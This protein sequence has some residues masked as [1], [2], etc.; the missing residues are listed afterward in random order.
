MDHVIEFIERGFTIVRGLFSDDELRAMSSALDNVIDQVRS[1]PLEYSVR[2]TAKDPQNQ[3]TWGVNY[4]FSRELYKPAFAIPFES[5]ALMTTLKEILGER[6]RFGNAHALWSPERVD[7]EL[8]WHRDSS[9]YRPEHT[10]GPRAHVQFNVCLEDDSSFRAVPGSHHRP[11][12]DDELNLVE[13]RQI[14]PLPGEEV[15][16]CRRGDVLLMNAN[17]VHRGSCAAGTLRRTLH[18]SVQPYGEASGGH[19]S[20]RFMRAEGFLDEMM[21][22]VRELMENLIQWDDTHP[23]PP[24]ER[25]ARLRLSRAIARQVSGSNSSSD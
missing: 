3:D 21:P 12:T 23:L 20:W 1:A 2:N 8:Y 14:A 16:T 13:T 4:I 7:Y 25:M 11:L 18:M 15:A 22:A 5:P 10:P 19:D 9:E 17:T 24:S 6:L